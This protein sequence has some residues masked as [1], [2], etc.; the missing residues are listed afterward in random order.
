MAEKKRTFYVRRIVF[1]L[2]AAAV[3]IPLLVNLEFPMIVGWPAR[4]LYEA[5]EKVPPDKIIVI[6][7]SW[8][9]GSQGECAPQTE[10]LI[11]HLVK[12]GKRFAVFSFSDVQGPE[13]V[14]RIAEPLAKKYGR[15]YGVDWVNWGYRTGASTMLRAWAKDIWQAVKEDA[16]GTPMEEL[17]L[18]QHVRSHED[19]GLIVDISAGSLGGTPTVLYYVQFLKGMYNVPVGY[20]CTGV[21]AAEAFPYLDSGQLVGMMRGLAGAA[22]YEKLV[23]FRGD[24]TRRMTAQSFAHVLVIALIILGNAGYFLLGRR[25]KESNAGLK[26]AESE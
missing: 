7:S 25:R 11:H 12:S 18:M 19:I 24:G 5:V 2:T 22:E 21:M 4:N 8:S 16:N 15:E 17:P 14:Q 20:G 13:L 10:A 6:S 3:A 26:E 1:A 23:G 9:A